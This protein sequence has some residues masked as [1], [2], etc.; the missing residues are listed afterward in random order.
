MVT[1]VACSVFQVS[2]V[3]WPVVM[4]LG[5]AVNEA[6]GARIGGDIEGANGRAL[7]FVEWLALLGYRRR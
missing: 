7:D 1:S 3:D 6:V 5:L 4:V 2:V